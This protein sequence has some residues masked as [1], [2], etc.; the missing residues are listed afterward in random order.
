MSEVK[1]NLSE[2]EMPQKWYNI[3]ADLPEP[4]APPINPKTRKPIGPEDLAPIFPMELIKQEVNVK[5]IA[6]G[7]KVKLDTKIREKLEKEGNWR[8]WIHQYKNLRK[9]TG[10]AQTDKISSI[11]STSSDITGQVDRQFLNE[12]NAKEY[13]E[14]ANEIDLGYFKKEIKIKGSKEYIGIKINK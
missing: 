6:F 14:V 4:L 1:I 12:I 9:S 8:E 2:K 13:Q 10:L 5:E 3:Q 7:N 11:T